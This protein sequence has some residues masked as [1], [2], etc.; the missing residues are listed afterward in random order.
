MRLLIPKGIWVFTSSFFKNIFPKSSCRFRRVF[1]LF[2]ASLLRSVLGVLLFSLEDW[3]PLLLRVRV[4]LGC[5][6]FFFSIAPWSCPNRMSFFWLGRLVFLWLS[7]FPF[8]SVL[9]LFFSAVRRN[10]SFVSFRVE[11]VFVFCLL[12]LLSKSFDFFVFCFLSMTVFAF[13]LLLAS[14]C[15][16]CLLPFVAFGWIVFGR[17]HIGFLTAVLLIGVLGFVAVICSSICTWVVRCRLVMA[18]VESQSKKA[19]SAYYVL[20]N[21]LE[22]G[23]TF[24][25]NGPRTM[26]KIIKCN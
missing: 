24:G 1:L 6:T 7:C 25:I 14:F 3:Q 9:L 22:R 17:F 4:D 16:E 19:I 10:E 20:F 15:L 2:K 12:S 23:F 5:A 11:S 21:V 18:F 26:I 8:E 13:W